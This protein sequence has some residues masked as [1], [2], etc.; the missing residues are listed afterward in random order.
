MR[1]R[2]SAQWSVPTDR[3]ASLWLV[4]GSLL[5][6][7]VCLI[8]MLP[9][10]AFAAPAASH[11]TTIGRTTSTQIED[12]VQQQAS[13]FHIPGTAVG[14]VNGSQPVLLKGFGNS[15]ADT[16]FFLNSLGKSFTALAIMQLVDQGK[17]NLDAPVRTYIP[18]FKIGDGSESNSITVLQVLDQTSGISTQAGLTALNFTPATTYVQAIE[19]FETFPLT[20]RP[21]TLYQYSNANYTIAGYIIQQVSGQSYTSYVQQHIFAP[22]GMTHTYAMSGTVR[23][24]GLTPGNLSWFGVISQPVTDTVAPPIVPEGEG[25]ISNVSDMTHYLI[26]QMNDGVYNGTRIVSAKAMQEMHAPLSPPTV[27]GLIPDATSYGMGWGVGT[28]SGQP[29]IVHGGQSHDF[30]AEMAILP[31]QKI[32]VVVLMN[33]QPQFLISDDAQLYDGVMQGITTGTFPSISQIFNVFYGVFDAIVLATLLLMILSF[34]RTGRWVQKF[35]GRVS[36]IGFWWAAARAVGLDLAIAA[37]IAVAVVYGLGSLTG[38]VPLTPA[39]MSY[40]APDVAAWIYAIILFFPVRAGVRMIVIASRGTGAQPR[41]DLSR[42]SVGD[43]A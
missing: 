32:A 5:S 16:S 3:A 27:P 20:A 33:Q 19:G 29:V 23:E 43:P 18:W 12:F 26:A 21:G 38:F 35:G 15:T 31:E 10:G 13:A 11:A 41:R 42:I 6:F 4:L 22:L 37:L 34:W 7:I 14:I 2:S 39:F 25:F 17:V 28:I 40:G 30:D 1:K 24:P 9:S 36:R 8:L